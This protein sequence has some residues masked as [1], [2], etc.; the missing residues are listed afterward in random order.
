M[1]P[2]IVLALIQK[3]KQTVFVELPSFFDDTRAIA[4]ALDQ[5]QPFA[6]VINTAATYHP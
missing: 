5:D 2:G 1:V 6:R 4:T 3:S